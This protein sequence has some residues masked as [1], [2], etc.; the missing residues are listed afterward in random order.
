M[1]AGTEHPSGSVSSLRAYPPKRSIQS[2]QDNAAVGTNTEPGARSIGQANGIDSIENYTIEPC[3]AKRCLTCST[4]ITSRSYSSNVTNRTYSVINHSNEKLTCKSSNLIYLLTCIN[5]NLQYVGE[6][7]TPLNVRMNTHR[8]S[9]MGCTHLIEHFRE[10][11]KHSSLTVQII[12]KLQG[13]GYNKY[14]TVDEEMKKTRLTRE[15][16]TIKALRVI[17]PYGLNSKTRKRNKNNENVGKLFPPLP[18][19]GERPKRSHKNRNNRS[20]ID[21]TI[22]LEEVEK[23]IK[24]DLKR[25][26]NQIRKL[27]NKTKKHILKKVASSIMI[28]PEKIYKAREY[29]QWYKFILDSI[30]TKCY[31]PTPEITKKIPKNVC[32][33]SYV[34]KGLDKIN[35]QKIIR[36]QEIIKNLPTKLQSREYNPMVTYKLG[37]TIRNKIFNYKNTVEN[38]K[39]EENGTV[40]LPECECATS[41]FT[42][43][44]IGHIITGNLKIIKNPKLRK[45]LAKGPNYREPKSINYNRCIKEIDIALDKCIKKMANKYKIT[46]TEFQLWK[47]MI[48][49]KAKNKSKKDSKLNKQ[50]ITKPTLKNPD[51]IKYLDAFKDKFV[52][53]PIDKA[54]NNI[55][56]ICKR[57]YILR[58]LE[59]I[60]FLG[61]PT[62]TYNITKRHPEEII[63]NNFEICRRLKI[64]TTENLR[65]LPI[66]YWMPKLHKTP[67]GARFI[68][69]SKT[70]SYKPL[71]KTISSIFKLIYKQIENYHNKSQFYSNFNLFWVIQNSKPVIDKIKHINASKKAKSIATY[72]FST[73]YTKIPHE[74]LIKNLNEI[75]DLAFAGGTNKY[76]IASETKAY[77]AK[78]KK[79]KCT[80]FTRSTLKDTV[81]HLIKESYFQIGDITLI[82]KIGIPMGIDPAPFW[83]NLYLHRHEYK[84]MIEHIKQ[85]TLK[86][87]K[88][89]SCIRFIDDMCCINDGGEFGRSCKNIYPKELV[90]KSENSGTKATFLDI[91]IEIEEGRFTF[92]LFDKRDAFPF[93][94]VRMPQYSSNIPKYIFYGSILAEFIR[95]ARSTLKLKDFVEKTTILIKRMVKQGGKQDRIF[96]QLNKALIRHRQTFLHYQTNFKTIIDR[97]KNA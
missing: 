30:D 9:K 21:S 48:I 14:G 69:A 79:D 67:T 2:R 65:S 84:F 71:S 76:I 44:N 39:I 16:E 75:I 88:F 28:S 96:K 51:V 87:K 19:T 20:N 86:A 11:C 12:E 40:K 32:V 61:T 10:T 68:I 54:T 56:C 74:D 45:L 42:D 78:D 73:L 33:I 52:I 13:N 25:S 62:P 36:S 41:E 15:D 57:H 7:T 72:D 34:N 27:I 35:I 97:I 63:F 18:R 64:E 60:G 4:L 47:Q 1:K 77:W 26:F 95:I 82:Q 6:T 23:Y 80:Y 38:I 22:F 49:D 50:K 58:I 5:C 46:I 37:P 83:A 90:L 8:T 59:E 24:N 43:P 85:N 93:H 55:A 94:I 81:T 29:Q 53:T 17:Y 70:C 66:M 31:K 89:H 92:K 3:G 91:N